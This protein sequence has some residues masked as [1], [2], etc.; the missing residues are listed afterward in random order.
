MAAFRDLEILVAKIQKHLA[1]N[2]NVQHNVSIE[3]RKSGRKRQIDV[4]VE[5]MVGQYKMNIVIDSKD[6][7]EPV[8]VKGVEEFAGLVDDVGAHKGVLVSP[9]GFTKAAKTRAA[10]LQ[11]ELYSPVDTDPHKWQ[12]KPT[13]P[14]IVDFR[15]PKFAFTLTTTHGGPFHLAEDFPATAHIYDATGK[16]LGTA[17]DVA[18][19]RWHEGVYQPEPEE[20]RGLP[21]FDTSPVFID[22]GN[23]GRAEIALAVNLIIEKQLYFGQ[24]PISQVSGFRDENTGAV[25]TRGFTT[26]NLDLIEIRDTWLKINDQSEAPY[27]PMMSVTALG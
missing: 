9:L 27:P 6:L 19:D 4:L 5:Q 11:I 1:P 8:D 13:I 20:Q 2:A 15:R 3:G 21:L 12:V 16:D 23:G 17:L 14:F 25:I 22:D 24:L 26:G 18:A 10:G 7:S